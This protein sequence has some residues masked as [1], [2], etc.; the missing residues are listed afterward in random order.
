[1]LGCNK[2]KFSKGKAMLGMVAGTFLGLFVGFLF[3]PKSGKETRKVILE[4]ATDDLNKK[5]AEMK[6]K[7]IDKVESA[8]EEFNVLV[9][10]VEK[11][12]G[13]IHEITE[14]FKDKVKETVA[15]KVKS[16]KDKGIFSIHTDEPE[17]NE[18]ESEVENKQEE[19]IEENEVVEV[20]N[21]EIVEEIAKQEFA[22]EVIEID[23][24]KKKVASKKA[25]KNEVT[26]NV[27]S[28]VKVNV[29]IHA[30]VENVN[31]PIE[32]LDEKVIMED[33]VKPKKTRKKKTVI[34]APTVEDAE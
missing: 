18:Y 25:I 27:N 21:E 17:N 8:Q 6:S 19:N 32:T 22:E 5:T 29:E 15:K 31:E 20:V 12:Q 2:R 9:E 13:E 30:E 3:A 23:I 16:K 10:K 1:M 33:I 24:P 14:D 26:D 11:A 7:V 28:D 34:I 4:K